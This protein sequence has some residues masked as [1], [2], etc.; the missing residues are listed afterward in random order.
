MKIPRTYPLGIYKYTPRYIFSPIPAWS[1]VPACNASLRDAGFDPCRG[2]RLQS[3]ASMDRRK[4]NAADDQR[5]GCDM[6]KMRH[7]TQECRRHHC[8]EQRRQIAEEARD[9]GSRA[10]YPRHP[11]SERR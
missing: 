10:L 9:A 4:H 3:R 8:R 2:R 11:S 7:F 1:S 6:V 5:E